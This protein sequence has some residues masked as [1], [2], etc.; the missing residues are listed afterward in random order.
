M[1][2]VYWAVIGF[3]CGAVVLLWYLRYEDGRTYEYKTKLL[4]EALALAQEQRPDTVWRVEWKDREI[5][6]PYKVVRIEHDTITLTDESCYVHWYS[7]TVHF[8]DLDLSYN[9]STVGTLEDFGIDYKLHG[10]KIVTLHEPCPPVVVP[11]L[12]K[13]S[14]M[15]LVGW[16]A[17][18]TMAVGRKLTPRMEVLGGINTSLVQP[19][20][21]AVVVGL[22]VDL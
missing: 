7:D 19:A 8:D 3:F 2:K 9:I 10:P 20:R 12:P 11:P 17:N 16:P 15:M 22:H 13:Y 5:P 4:T 14:A 18:A 6:K 1:S 21:A